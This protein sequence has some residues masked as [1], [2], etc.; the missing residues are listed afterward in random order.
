MPLSQKQLVL[1]RRKAGA[2]EDI[3]IDMDLMSQWTAQEAMQY[4]VNGGKM[5]DTDGP[6]PVRVERMAETN[7]DLECHAGSSMAGAE[8]SDIE[9]EEPEVELA[10]I[11]Y[12]RKHGTCLPEV[13]AIELQSKEER[14]WRE[15]Y[16]RR[17]NG[18]AGPASQQNKKLT[19]I[20]GTSTVTAGKFA[21]ALRKEE[22]SS[23]DD[24]DDEEESIESLVL[25]DSD[26]D[27]DEGSDSD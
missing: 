19:D 12:A 25:E 21:L 6:A 3:A 18:L 24:D 26:D 9:E 27:D 7:V 23:D 5:P 1:L 11:D 17:V 15:A 4:F 16:E 14:E 8:V 2:S 13:L 22:E 20:H 10:G